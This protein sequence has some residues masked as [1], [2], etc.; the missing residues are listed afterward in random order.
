MYCGIGIGVGVGIEANCFR[1]GESRGGL[2]QII[3]FSST[4]KDLEVIELLN[5]DLLIKMLRMMM[6]LALAL[7][8]AL[9]RN[10]CGLQLGG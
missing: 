4:M 9:G 3:K 2:S 7:A 10:C 1:F 8:L 5:E 6:P